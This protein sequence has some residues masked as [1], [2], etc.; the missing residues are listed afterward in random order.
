MCTRYP[1][2]N[3]VSELKVHI[4]LTRFVQPEKI[5]IDANERA[6]NEKSQYCFFVCTTFDSFLNDLS[7]HLK[8]RT[9]RQSGFWPVTISGKNSNQFLLVWHD[10][11]FHGWVA[12]NYLNQNVQH[13]CKSWCKCFGNSDVN[14]KALAVSRKCCGNKY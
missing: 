7:Y 13:V 8:T 10:P 6:V 11:E 14:E 4:E 5:E 3:R 2:I 12:E 1:I 9:A